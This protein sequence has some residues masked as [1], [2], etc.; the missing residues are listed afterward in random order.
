MSEVEVFDG[1][2]GWVR[3]DIGTVDGPTKKCQLK[4]V[5]VPRRGRQVAGVVPPFGLKF[6]VRAMISGERI[7]VSGFGLAE[8]GVRDSRFGPSFANDPS[9]AYTQAKVDDTEG[10]SGIRPRRV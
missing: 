9:E 8:S 10:T 6:I 1:P 5:L 7:P 2:D 4:P 3:L